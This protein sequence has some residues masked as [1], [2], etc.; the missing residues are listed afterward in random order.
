MVPRN[1]E[2]WEIYFF[3]VTV[4]PIYL[5]SSPI[6]VHRTCYPV[7]HSTVRRSASTLDTDVGAYPSSFAPWDGYV[8]LSLRFDSRAA[9]RPDSPVT[10]HPWHALALRLDLQQRPGGIAR[11]GYRRICVQSPSGSSTLHCTRH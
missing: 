5:L 9:R 10:P 3:L 7:L 1:S 11:D 6:I 4:G 2:N 8:R